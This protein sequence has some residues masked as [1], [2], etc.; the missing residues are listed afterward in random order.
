DHLAQ[1]QEITQ[2]YNVAVNDG[3]GGI[4]TQVVT[5]T[6]T[7]TNDAPEIE[8][9]AGDSAAKSLDET[10]TTLKADGTLSLLDVDVIDVVTATAVNSITKGGT[11]TGTLPTDAE[12]KAMF[13]VT[14][15]LT[16]TES[17]KD[18]GITWKF[19]SGSHYFDELAKGETLEL[20]YTV[21]V[22]DPHGGIDT[23][24]VV[25]TITGT[26]DLPVIN[27]V[28]ANDVKGAVTEI[29]DKALGENVDDHTVNGYFE[30]TDADLS[31]A[32]SVSA[33]PQGVGYLGTFTPVV[34]TQ[35]TGGATGKITW[36]FVVNDAD[37]DHLAQGQ[38]ITQTYNVAVN[39]GNGGITT[40]VVTVTITG[41]NDAP[42]IHERAGDSWE[43]DLTEVDE[44]SDPSAD[45]TLTASGT[46]SIVDVD[47]IDVVTPSVESVSIRGDSTFGGTFGSGLPSYEEVLAML[48][49]SGGL[50]N[51][52][53]DETGGITWNFNSTE[54]S[55]YYFDELAEG[56]KLILVY[57][58]KATD[59]SGASDTHDVII[60]ITGTND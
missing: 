25:I 36:N 2:T 55:N 37:L 46:L 29:A 35:T 57:T 54:T 38:E 16:N 17:D 40:Q 21:Q 45:K 11:Y 43:A 49:V 13:T 1:G 15:G 26:N 39:D 53:T 41:T 56:D 47:V 6:I 60:T 51:T 27:V 10:D 42:E 28:N 59:I 52:Q 3:N 44:I 9:R 4:T 22:A 48:T 12:L 5:V 18:H 19:D 34:D 20:T 33:T 32:V 30:V 31:D 23:K 7:G 24:D 58:V 8:I 50:T 14:G